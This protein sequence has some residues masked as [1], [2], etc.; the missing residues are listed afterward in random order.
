MSKGETN[1]LSD[2]VTNHQKGAEHQPRGKGTDLSA[3]A[4]GF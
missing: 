4:K 2:E 3:S 1:A